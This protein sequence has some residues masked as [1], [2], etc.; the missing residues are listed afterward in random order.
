VI[1]LRRSHLGEC[2]QGDGFRG[3]CFGAGKI[4]WLEPEI[5]KTFE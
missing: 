4:T 2:R 1:L 5:L 3:G